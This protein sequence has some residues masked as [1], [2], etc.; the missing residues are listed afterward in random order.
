MLLAE[1]DHVY[2]VIYMFQNIANDDEVELAVFGV[3]F[4]KDVVVFVES[5][6]NLVR[7]LHIFA[8]FGLD[9]DLVGVFRVKNAVSAGSGSDF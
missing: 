9:G 8:V 6:W 5:A 1:V 7:G 4:V 3:L 2:R